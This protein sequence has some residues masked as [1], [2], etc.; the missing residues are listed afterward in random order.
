MRAIAATG[1]EGYVGHEPLPKAAALAAMRA[2]FET[3][4]V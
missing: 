4:D 1:Y 3:F 2:A